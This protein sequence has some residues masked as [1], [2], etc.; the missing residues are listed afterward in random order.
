MLLP[1]TISDSNSLL[2]D[3]LPRIT[4]GSSEVRYETNTGTGSY[5]PLTDDTVTVPNV[6][7]ATVQPFFYIP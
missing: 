4:F 7:T 2:V 1:I 3:T 6:C 5:A